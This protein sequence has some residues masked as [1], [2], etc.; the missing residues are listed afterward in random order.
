MAVR[1][2]IGARY[3]I[4]VYENSLDQSSAEWEAGVTY[5]PLTLVTYNYSSYLSKKEVPRS[6]GDPA[7]NPAYWVVTGAYNGQILTLQNEIDEIKD[8]EVFFNV[9]FPPVDSGIAP[10]D[11]TGVSD[12]TAQLQAIVDYVGNKN[13]GV[14]YFPTG[15][16]SI[17]GT[18]DCDY[19]HI[20]FMGENRASTWLIHSSNE[21]MFHVHDV[22]YCYFKH[23]IFRTYNADPSTTSQY[24]LFEDTNYCVC[25]DLSFMDGCRFIK[26]KHA[27]GSKVY[28]VLF[29]APNITPTNKII[30]IELE[31]SCVSSRFLRV[32]C[33]FLGIGTTPGATGI[34]TNTH[35]QDIYIE[36][37]ESAGCNPSIYIQNTTAQ[38]PGDIIIKNSIFDGLKGYGIHL[39]DIKAATYDNTNIIDGIYANAYNTDSIFLMRIEDSNHVNVAHVGFNNHHNRKDIGGIQLARC[40]HSQVNDCDFTHCS[41]GCYIIDS[42]YCTCSNNVLSIGGETEYYDSTTFRFIMGINFSGASKRCAAI[43]NV[44]DGAET[45]FSLSATSEKNI[46]SLNNVGAGSVTDSGTNNQVADNLT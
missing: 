28:D 44:F 36:R 11:N 32:T 3:V 37:Y 7:S 25:E 4:K 14:I 5:E 39:K 23:L 22:N 40:K 9:C 6:V 13:G 31:N 1:Q 20:T 29:N 16:Y 19:A 43:G 46:V 12:C 34:Y 33:N 45:A 21:I 42:E 27:P 17:E 24:I 15:R 41:K 8:N 26:F 35:A 2:Y 38:N 30:A 10:L 18:V